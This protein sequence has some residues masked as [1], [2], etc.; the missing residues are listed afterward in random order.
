VTDVLSSIPLLGWGPII[1]IAAL[2]VVCLVIAI[3]L[4]RNHKVWRWV[5]VALFLI[6]GL[7]AVGDWANTHWAKYDTAADLFGIPNYPTVDGNVSGPNVKPQ[8]N[9]A[10]IEVNVPDTQSKFGNFP[11]KVWLPPQYFTDTRALFPVVILAHGNP[12]DNSA[13][14]QASNAAGTGLK[15]AQSG[16]PVILVM[17]Q[18][19]QNTITGDSLCVDTQSQG[20]AETYIT[21]DVIAAADKQLRTM[22]DAKHRG[23]G[24]MSMGGFCALNLGLKHPDLFS[25]VLDFSGETKPIADTLPDG[26]SELFGANWQQQADANDPAKY[27]VTL[28]GSRGPAIWMDVGTGDTQ[29]LADMKALAPLLQSKGFTVEVHTRPG[30]HDFV[31]WGN[32]LADALP[33]AAARFYS[34]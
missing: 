19:L 26:L 24:G 8:P 17:P 10:V 13:W 5:F 21:Q 2:A 23:I 32:G 12:S 25:V 1:T 15:A 6:V 34:P 33:W 28:N 27:Y 16:K 11:A 29:I 20:N 9:G 22:P 31:T 4:W 3:L 14:L 30:A 18:V 7:G